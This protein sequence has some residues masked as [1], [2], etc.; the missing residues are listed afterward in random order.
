MTP[1]LFDIL[2]RFQSQL[3]AL[4]ADIEKAFHQISINENDRDYL[5]FLWF[6]NVFSDQPTIVRNRF[7]RALFGVTSSPFCL[8]ATV[9]KHA[10]N[11]EFDPEFVE[12]VLSSFFVDDFVGGETNQNKAFELFKKLQLRFSDGHF[13]LQ[14]WRTNHAELRKQIYEVSSCQPSS[15][16]VLGIVWDDLND[17]LVFDLETLYAAAKD[18]P[19]TKRNVLKII[20]SF[21]DPLGLL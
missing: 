2:L 5:R 14:K 16:K 3:I 13:W 8:N 18:L 12:A 21:F 6:D 1:L 19:P 4:T 17:K 15:K 11:Y 20:A 9:R 7:A 10:K